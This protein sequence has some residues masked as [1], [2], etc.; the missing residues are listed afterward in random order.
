MNSNEF[1]EFFNKNSYKKAFLVKNKD[2]LEKVI[3]MPVSR[4]EAYL[5]L[6]NKGA[7]DCGYDYFCFLLRK[8][9]EEKTTPKEKVKSEEHQTES[10]SKVVTTS[11]VEAQTNLG[12]VKAAKKEIIS[13]TQ[14]KV[15]FHYDP[16]EDIQIF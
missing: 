5:F 1:E 7:L 14:E 13:K 4:K 6:K 3:N 15:P 8:L 2:F 9:K 12:S 11:K 16:T 10:K